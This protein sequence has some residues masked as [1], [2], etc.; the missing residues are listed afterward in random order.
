MD[1][2]RIAGAGKQAAGAVKDAAG[3]LTGDKKLQG[4]A[5][6]EKTEGNVQNTFGKAK[7]AL[8]DTANKGG[9]T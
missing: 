8:R 4:E 3:K 5:K 6:A 9:S 2:D 7:D 1:K